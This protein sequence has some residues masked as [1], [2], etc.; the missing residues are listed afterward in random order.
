MSRSDRGRGVKRA[1]RS[2]LRYPWAAAL[3]P[4]GLALGVGGLVQHA[5]R[6]ARRRGR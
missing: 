6:T 3:I 4:V 1:A 2:L 5:V